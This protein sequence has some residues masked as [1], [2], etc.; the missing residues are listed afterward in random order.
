[1]HERHGGTGK[2]LTRSCK[3][4]PVRPIQGHSEGIDV[5]PGP[6]K[7]Q[8]HSPSA[9]QGVNNNPAHH[10]LA[11]DT[12]CLLLSRSIFLY[13]GGVIDGSGSKVNIR[14]YVMIIWCQ[15]HRQSD[16]I[17]PR[18]GVPLAK[19]NR[20]FEVSVLTFSIIWVQ[21]KNERTQV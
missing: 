1:M 2:A 14:L 11:S 3:V 19:C 17:N 15:A 20:H 8:G 6:R 18:F 21:I 10:T 7:N 4:L 13:S 9:L 12:T 5:A 16:H